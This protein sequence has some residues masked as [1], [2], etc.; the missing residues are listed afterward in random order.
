MCGVWFG[1]VAS[2]YAG[3]AVDNPNAVV[4]GLAPSQFHYNQLNEAFR[5]ATS[6]ICY[7][8]SEIKLFCEVTKFSVISCSYCFTRRFRESTKFR[9]H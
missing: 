3:I 7:G 1:H 5:S 6:C 2:V 4:V 9:M 8:E